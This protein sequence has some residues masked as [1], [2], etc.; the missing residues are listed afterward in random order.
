LRDHARAMISRSPRC[1]MRPHA[2]APG[3][4]R[5]SIVGRRAL[6]ALR[7]RWRGVGLST[8]TCPSRENGSHLKVG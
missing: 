4:R 6:T 8:R 1:T 3:R 5:S 7:R 2:S